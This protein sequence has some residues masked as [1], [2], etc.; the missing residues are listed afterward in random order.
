MKINSIITREV[1]VDQGDPNIMVDQVGVDSVADLEGQVVNK[2]I[3]E[4]GA[5]EVSKVD[6]EGLEDIMV[7]VDSEDRETIKVEGIWWT[8]RA[9]GA[10]RT[11][12]SWRKMVKVLE[13]SDTPNYIS[14]NRSLASFQSR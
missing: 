10:R 3:M 6:L 13:R 7:G 2:D 8:R 12:R 11:R 1:S 4:A 14:M 5:L 9:R